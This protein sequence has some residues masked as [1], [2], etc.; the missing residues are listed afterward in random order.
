MENLKLKGNPARGLIGPTLGFFI[1]CTVVSLFGPTATIFKEIFVHLNPMLISLLVAAPSLSGSLLRIP[2]SAWVDTTGGKK[3]LFVLLILYILGMLGL[4]ILI[5]FFRHDLSNNYLLVLIFSLVAG[6]GLATFS[7]G[8]SQTSYWFPKSK[9]GIAL[10]IYGGIGNLGPG[11]LTVV[12][13]FLLASLSLS[14]TYLAWLIFV[15][16]GTI[17]YFLI[18]ENAWY[19]QLLKKGFKKEDAISYAEKHYGQELFPRVKV[20][21]SLAISGKSW[22]TWALTMIYF[23]TFGGFLALTAWFPEYFETFFHI[24]LTTAAIFTAI[25]SILASLIRVYGGKLS[26]KFSGEKICLLSLIVTL[27]GSI[28]MTFAFSL[29]LALVGIIILAI[30][31]GIANA[32]VFKMVPNAVPE[33]MGGASGW[34]GGLGGL[35][36]FFVPLAL[37]LFISG[38]NLS[39][40]ATG[41]VIFIILTLISLL[42]MYLLRPKKKFNA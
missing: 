1:G 24:D 11:I 33:A 4:Y 36:G 12:V 9:Q 6:C 16:I 19:F 34:V 40:Y 22:K 35:G 28:I 37:T 25:F 42:M 13:P 26:D 23:T 32:A 27:I 8:I 15:V 30:G 20:T 18:A 2:F 29:P 17:L 14:G 38:G 7:V 39:G 10:G 21:Q 31:M 41:F 5:T 3:P